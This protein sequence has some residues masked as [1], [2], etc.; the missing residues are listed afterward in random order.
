MQSADAGD[1]SSSEE[2]FDEK[3][4]QEVTHAVVPGQHQG[5]QDSDEDA[6]FLLLSD[7]LAELAESNDAAALRKADWLGG[8]P[9]AS[10]DSTS[11]RAPGGAAA[12]S[13]RASKN[14]ADHDP[15]DGL[16]EDHD[17][18]KDGPAKPK[19]RARQNTIRLE[20][21]DRLRLLRILETSLICMTAR[22]Q[23]ISELANHPVARAFALSY[24]GGR[25]SVVEGREPTLQEGGG[26]SVANGA[27]GVSGSSG[28]EDEEEPNPK[29][30]KMVLEQ[31]AEPY[32][33][34]GNQTDHSRATLRHRELSSFSDCVPD[35]QALSL[36]HILKANSPIASLILR[37]SHNRFFVKKKH[38]PPTV[39][40]VASTL[41]SFRILQLRVY[42]ENLFSDDNI[43]RAKADLALQLK[44]ARLKRRIAA[45]PTSAAGG[46]SSGVAKTSSKSIYKNSFSQ[47]CY[48]VTLGDANGPWTRLSTTPT[49]PPSNNNKLPSKFLF[50][51]SFPNFDPNTKPPSFKNRPYLLGF[52]KKQKLL[53]KIQFSALCSPL[54]RWW[55]SVR[56][57]HFYAVTK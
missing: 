20:L 32:R 49:G 25:T 40:W 41:P 22:A 48:L 5:S 19:K 23:R 9:G 11:S 57:E 43:D 12:S 6:D 34:R 33:L 26:G 14:A 53:D 7:G 47:D 30:A 17:G 50:S 51:P 46:P 16:L 4:W 21:A 56:R 35:V 37:L 36:L 44:C 27:A 8:L 45:G 54:K 10:V 55:L 15:L 1:F 38:E 52:D 3:D 18:G 39:V 13:S 29:R 24:L 28:G 31:E 42:H 2:E